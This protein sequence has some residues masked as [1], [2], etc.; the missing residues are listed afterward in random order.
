MVPVLATVSIQERLMSESSS[1]TTVY[2]EWSNESSAWLCPTLAL[3][4]CELRGVVTK[5][6]A[7]SEQ[8]PVNK[9]H[10]Q[11]TP[12]SDPKIMWTGSTEDRPTSAYALIAVSPKPP[13]TF[14]GIPI[15]VFGPV[16]ALVLGLTGGWTAN[17][18]GTTKD[19][20]SNLQAQIQ[21]LIE[22]KSLAINKLQDQQDTLSPYQHVHKTEH[23]LLVQRPSEERVLYLYG[24]SHGLRIEAFGRDNKDNPVLKSGNIAAEK[25][26]MNTLLGGAI[27]KEVF[28]KG[29]SMG[30]AAANRV[31]GL[32]DPSAITVSSLESNR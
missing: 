5:F 23:N 16:V 29:K 17:S 28:T 7:G 31:L 21:V 9:Y 4:Y 1:D 6:D 3:P 22:E 19:D 2:L 32:A 20:V 8:L 14:L 12:G 10:L 27:D 11:K 24:M 25:S 26:Y 15:A 13:G 18:T 30:Q